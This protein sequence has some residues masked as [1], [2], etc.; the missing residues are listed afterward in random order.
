[1][2]TA[3]SREKKSESESRLAEE[4]ST[5]VVDTPMRSPGG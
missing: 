5:G 2:P 4:N 3:C 1:M